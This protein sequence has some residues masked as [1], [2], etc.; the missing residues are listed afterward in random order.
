MLRLEL[1]H[2]LGQ[3]AL[4]LD[5]VRDARDPVVFGSGRTA[6]VAVPSAC[7]TGRHC[8]IFFNGATRQ[9]VL[10]DGQTRGR[11]LY[12]DYA[13]DDARRSFALS[14]GDAIVLGDGPAP[15][16]I[17]VTAVLPPI[18]RKTPRSTVRPKHRK[19]YPVLMAITGL[20]AIAAFGSGA[21]WI[22]NRRPA[23]ATPTLVADGPTADPGDA[24][25]ALA[26]FPQPEVEANTP[27][28]QE[29]PVEATPT[30][31]EP[32][33]PAAPPAVDAAGFSGDIAGLPADHPH[34][35]SAAWATVA[36]A[37]QHP[38]V[39]ERLRAYQEYRALPIGLAGPLL[40]EVGGWI[41]AELDALW[42]QRIGELL[43]EERQQ[44]EAA[45]D[46]EMALRDP[47]V[48]ADG[49]RADRLR[50]ELVAAQQRVRLIALTL[51]ETMGYYEAEAPSTGDAE[52]LARLRDRRDERL[53]GIWRREVL[54]QARADATLP[55]DTVSPSA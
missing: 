6:D 33:A 4:D 21:W 42:W 30:P 15:A 32:P 25:R 7:V 27:A 29:V 22:W 41:D 18:E 3:Q 46:L 49:D 36:S 13:I 12:N 55:W 16:T 14:A 44:M 28:T 17:R 8:A 31:A 24:A 10:Q 37:R 40:D 39:G 11:T 19:R 20:A 53:Y 45:L 47:D 34:R 51:S 26:P 9:W 52:Q 23:V 2:P 1:T 38:Q 48:L 43:D 50:A 54:E 5:E 35:A